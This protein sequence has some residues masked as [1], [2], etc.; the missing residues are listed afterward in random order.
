MTA[1]LQAGRIVVLDSINTFADGAA[2]KSVGKNTFRIVQHVVDEMVLVTTDEIC[3][4]I[5]RGFSDSRVLLEPAGAL[6]IAGLVKYVLANKLEN[7]NLIA[8]T[9][10]ANMDFDRLRHVSERADTSEHLLSVTIPEKPG[11]FLKLCEAVFPHQITEFSYRIEYPF[12]YEATCENSLGR[13]K[14]MM[15]VKVNDEDPASANP[16]KALPKMFDRLGFSAR[17]LDDEASKVHLRHLGGGRTPWN[18]DEV[19][20]RNHGSDNARVLS[21]IQVPQEDKTEFNDFIE[22]LS[23]RGIKCF[24][25]TEN[26]T[27][28]EFVTGYSSLED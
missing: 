25:E 7:K 12:K 24:E 13:A 28:R 20:Y 17:Y 4:A 21:G 26:E 22:K 27:L 2:L 23:A 10:G 1:S 16:S 5:K 18:N 15:S 9:S 11:A 6:A 19:V 14:I 3:S 8:V